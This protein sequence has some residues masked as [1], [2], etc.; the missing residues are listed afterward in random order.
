MMHLRINPNHVILGWYYIGN[1]LEEDAVK[2]VH[3]QI[4]EETMGFDAICL[5]VDMDLLQ[6]AS[7]FPLDFSIA[8]VVETV[9]F[10]IF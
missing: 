7:E 4:Q 5:H 2:T 9:K 3:R 1:D 6:V 8:Y 10:F